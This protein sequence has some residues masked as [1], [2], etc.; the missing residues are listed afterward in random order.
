MTSQGD[1]LIASLPGVVTGLRPRGRGW[2]PSARTA[3]RW[4]RPSS[5]PSRAFLAATAPA[6]QKRSRTGLPASATYRGRCTGSRTAERVPVP[7]AQPAAQAE[8]EALGW[9]C[10]GV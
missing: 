2:P 4:P 1:I 10:V 6:A 5:V 8:R 7:T 9:Q 3:L